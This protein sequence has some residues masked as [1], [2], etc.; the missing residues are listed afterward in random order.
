MLTAPGGLGG[1]PGL[2]RRVL[3]KSALAAGRG[4]G[5]VLL[6]PVSLVA[7]WIGLL[8]GLT[9]FAQEALTGTYYAHDPSTIVKDGSRYFFFRTSA[10][11]RFNWS[12]NLTHWNDTGD[13]IFPSGP[14]GWV[15]SAVTG[16]DPNNWSWAPDV[17][18]FNGRYH[19]Y[20]SVSEW[21][22][23]D[24]VIG[25]VTSPSL[26]AP[27]WTDQGKVVQSDASGEAGPD[28]DTTSH[29]CID[30][31]ILQATNGTIWMVYGSYSD[32][33]VVTQLDP[34][35]GKRLNPGS[36]GVKIADNGPVF[37]SN[38]TEAAHLHQRGGY[39][40]LFLNFGGCCQ[41][42]NS[43]YNIRVGR[44]TSV[45]GPYIDHEGVSMLNGGGTMLLQTSGRYI[46]P[47][48]AGILSED[49]TDW[50]SY[51]YY[52]GQE[53]GNA[54][55]GLHQL[56]WT[57]DGWPDATGDA[58]AFA[59]FYPF[60]V[61]ARDHL[62]LY[63]AQLMGG[64]TITPEPA[65]GGVLQLDGVSGYVRL[66]GTMV[67]GRTFAAWVRWG[68]GATW[69]RIFDFGDGTIG[70]T[71]GRYLFLS[72][73]ASSG[74]LRFAITTSG[75]Q[76]EQIIDAPFALPTNSWTHVA[77]TLEPGRGLLYVNGQPAG[78][79][80]AM[81]LS[82]GDISARSNYLGR[83]QWP[84]PLFNGWI[85][86]FRAYGRTLGSNE[87][88]DLALAPPTLAHRYSFTADAH[89]AFGA[90]DGTIMGAAAVTS[91]AL[92]LNGVA[93]DYLDLP[94]GLVSGCSAVTIE[95]WAELGASGSL[96][97]VFDFGDDSHPIIGLNYVAFI[98]NNGSG[99]HRFSLST[100]GGTANLDAAGN[101][102][103]QTV[104][105]VCM[106]DPA[107]GYTAIYANGVLES[108]QTGT[109][110]PLS[111]VSALRS[112]IGRSLWPSHGWLDANLD[113]FR[114]YH[115]RLSPEQIA[116][117]HRAGP[118]PVTIPVRLDWLSSTGGLTLRW[119]DYAVGFVLEN[120]PAPGPGAVWTRVAVPPVLNGA[121]HGVTLT[122]PGQNLFFRL[123]Q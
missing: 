72:P 40:Y 5:R 102:N 47:G 16:Y 1:D 80:N 116:A 9:G 117:N 90:A 99:T 92:V 56:Q 82:P 41:G 101:L 57:A 10:G 83:S 2:R 89:D 114:I 36:A 12:D 84:D 71:T 43:T 121:S 74:K 46:G 97:R 22:T 42:T 77:V 105:V 19:V 78:T 28:T 21:G 8:H 119:P 24:S 63:N 109:V 39:Y 11:I 115:G 95:F 54:K 50:L 120:S 110:P 45:T 104:H 18:F 108:E 33:I 59:A 44:S 20:Y 86:S 27:T 75:N 69:Q 60:E 100:S 37:F 122:N 48:H 87:I 107:A 113:E 29:N 73:R 96:A 7:A 26:L 3:Q 6:R 68:G 14:P 52:D 25:L 93:G 31:S 49:S 106:V 23:I 103:G 88:A 81:T 4:W 15:T 85:D 51:H 123:R 67:N 61:D 13:R 66:P 30:P 79:N 91:G 111:T 32:G 38:T 70:A 112:F 76:N 62:G 53:N 98:P 118:D 58:T 94:G 55:L 64:A 17:A 35:T 34:A 65:R